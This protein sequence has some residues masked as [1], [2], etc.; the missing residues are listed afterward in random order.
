M[1]VEAEHSSEEDDAECLS[2]DNEGDCYEPDFVQCTQLCGKEE[3][4]AL[5]HALHCD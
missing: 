1:D 2:T 3:R 5:E 4:L